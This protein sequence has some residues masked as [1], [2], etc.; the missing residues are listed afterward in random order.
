MNETSSTSPSYATVEFCIGDEL[1]IAKVIANASSTPLTSEG[2]ESL[3]QNSGYGNHQLEPDILQTLA[4]MSKANESSELDIEAHIDAKF[5][6]E[7]DDQQISATLSYSPAFCGEELTYDTIM[8][9]INELAIPEHK[10]NH[11]QIQQLLSDAVDAEV[12]IAKGM[13][14]ID[15]DDGT[16]DVIYDADPNTGPRRLAN[17]QVDHYE[18]HTYITVESDTVLLQRNPP[19]T[20]TDGLTIFDEP[21]PATPGQ[22]VQFDLNETV[23]LSADDENIL[24]AARSGHPLLKPNSVTIDDT[25]TLDEASLDTGNV[26]FNG[27]VHI[28]GDVK[29]NIKIQASGDI[30]V[31]GLVENSKLIAGNNVTIESGIISASSTDDSNSNSD[32]VGTVITAEHDIQLKYCNGI[33]AIAGGSILIEN[34]SM[35]SH[36]HAKENVI[37]GINNGKGILIGGD[38]KAD[39]MIEANIIGSEAFVDTA[40][41]CADNTLIQTQNR[42]LKQTITR[43]TNELSMLTEILE[44]IKASGNPATVSKAT[45]NKAKKI[46]LETLALKQ[47]I[48]EYKRQIQSLMLQIKEDKSNQIQVNNTIYPNVSMVINDVHDKTKITR[49][50]CIIRKVNNELDFIQD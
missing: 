39:H 38:T 45:L 4:D 40:L 27:S 35:H 3:L 48:T 14:A 42:K 25:L 26:N 5:S 15:G 18:T 32:A 49:S 19:T 36:L 7:I 9:A 41:Y 43:A 24:V 28:K 22:D 1:L 50:R 10:I 37:L 16:I 47:D 44:K 12:I 33:K 17:G 30:Y 11:E 46:H 29:P 21:I 23:K 8:M 13:A 34:Y 20:G 2:I 6:I 31:G